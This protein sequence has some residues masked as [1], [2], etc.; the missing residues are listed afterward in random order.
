[1][2]FLKT[3]ALGALLLTAAPAL[4]QEPATMPAAAPAAPDY[5]QAANWLCLPGRGDICAQPIP[6]TALNANGYGSTGQA[7]PAA[8]PAIDCFYVYPT[9]SHDPGLNSDLQAGP[10]ETYTAQAQFARFASVCRPFV[11]I[12]RQAT[13]AAL[14]GQLS[15]GGGAAQAMA[16]AYDDVLAAWR[17]YL[18]TRN[19]GRSVV[20]IGHSQGTIHLTRLLA[21]EI[22]NGPA[23][24]RLLSAILLGFPVEVPEGKLVGGT[25]KKTPLCSRVGETGCVITYTSFRATNPPPPGSM[26]GRATNP[27]M[28]AACTNPAR[29]R[30]GSA[31]LDSYWPTG[32]LLSG[33]P[34]TIAWSKEGTPPS[35]YLRT[36]GLVSA[37]CVNRGAVGYL[38]VMVN[39]DPADARTDQI[40]GDV[41]VAGQSLPGWGLH[42]ADMALA[43]GDLVALVEAQAAAFR[44]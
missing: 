35:P 13:L 30:Q 4:A 9:V 25:F 38:A 14:L 41:A 12:Y 1:M 39:A 16:T 24:S 10:E 7:M 27:G 5:T 20:L 32:V 15:G 18:E 34:D 22:E 42:L 19:Q 17:N 31:T 36:E 6:T 2:G 11:P 29:L 23:A 33:R 43:Q 44:R 3:L 21:S 37:S 28:T 40:P 26:F 8:D